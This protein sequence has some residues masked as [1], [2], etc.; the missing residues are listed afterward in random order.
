MRGEKGATD[1]K[2]NTQS[3]LVLPAEVGADCDPGN[4][5]LKGAP[6]FRAHLLGTAGWGSFRKRNSTLTYFA[7]FL[8]LKRCPE[9]M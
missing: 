9:F 5:T 8:S 2:I 1:G 6:V 3:I 4:I 7:M